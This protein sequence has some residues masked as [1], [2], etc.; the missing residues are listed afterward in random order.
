[1]FSAIR[2]RVR[3]TP[4]GVVAV[5]ALVLAMSGG[6]YAAGRYAITSTK[7]ISPKVLK[8]LAGRARG[9][10]CAGSSWRGGFGWGAPARRVWRAGRALKVKRA[11]LAKKAQPVKRGRRARPAHRGRPAGR[12]RWKRLRPEA[13]R[14]ATVAASPLARVCP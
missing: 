2:R 6:A 3:V 1:M 4:S 7:Q 14:W 10:R 9:G 5:F 11:P 13:G 12:F 8:A